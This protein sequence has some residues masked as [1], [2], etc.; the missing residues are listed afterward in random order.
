MRYTLRFHAV[1]AD[2][3]GILRTSKQINEIPCK[4]ISEART[5]HA[6]ASPLEKAEVVDNVTGKTIL[7]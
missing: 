5:L 2:H 4:T 1:S 6:A 7:S 3:L